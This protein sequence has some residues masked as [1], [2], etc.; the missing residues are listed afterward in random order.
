MSSAVNMAGLTAVWRRQVIS[1]LGNPLGYLFILAFVVASA[2]ILFLPETFFTRNL[3]DLGYLLSWDGFPMMPALLAVLV[4]ALGMG[5][6][7]AERESGT[8]E[9]LLTMPFSLLDAVLGK[10]FAVMTFVTIALGCSLSNVAIL[11]WIGSPDAGLVF[12]NYLGWWLCAAVFSA[13]SL[14]ASVLVVVPAFAFVLGMLFCLTLLAVGVQVD[15]FAGFNRGVMPVSSVIGA[16]AAAGAGLGIVLLALASRRWR[17]GHEQR[18]FLHCLSAVLALV[19]AVNLGR[20]G[21]RFGI[22]T[23]LSNDGIASLASESVGILQGLERPVQVTAFISQRLP[24]G[25]QI[26]AKRVEDTLAAIERFGGN[27]VEVDILRPRNALSDAALHAQRDF[28]LK[29]RK[30]MVDT[31]LGRELSDVYLSVAITSA[32]RTHLIEY[33]DPGLHVEYELLQGIR[34]V[35][36]DAKRVIGV[37]RTDLE[38]APGF[39][40][41]TQQM[42]P[43]WQLYEQWKK[44]Y[45]VRDVDLDSAVAAEI[46]VLVV[47]QP[48]GLTDAQ[49]R[50]L[51][52]YIW[53]G[54]PTLLMEDPLPM[55]SGP[56]LAAGQPRRQQGGPYGQPDQSEPKGNLRPLWRSLGL[57]FNMN[58]VVWSEYN[59]SHAHR[60][61]IPKSFV[62]CHR[63]G[64]SF[65]DSPLTRGFTDLLFAW[66]G[67][68]GVATDKPSTITVTPLVTATPGSNWGW[69]A[70]DEYF[71]QGWGGMQQREITRWIPAMDEV[72]AIAVQVTGKM[73][74][75]FPKP[76][77]NAPKP[78]GEGEAAPVEEREGIPSAQDINVIVVADT[79]FCNDMFFQFYRDE[80]SR[81]SQQKELTFLKDLRNV[82]FAANLVDGLAGEEGLVGVRSRLMPLRKLDFIDAQVQKAVQARNAAE[83]SAKSAAEAQI[84]EKRAALEADVAKIDQRSDL[85]AAAKS[86]LKELTRANRSRELEVD[87][88]RINEQLELE[89]LASRAE[90]ERRIEVIRFQ[91]RTGAI[92]IPFLILAGIALLVF[93]R[94]VVRESTHVPAARARS[95][96]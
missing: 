93:L 66:P 68:I 89:N 43:A 31:S 11:S 5:A 47:P 53:D 76:D 32:G 86:E 49:I 12:A 16:I 71:T 61:V 20:I 82:Q 15:F 70:W 28:G 57:D 33:V 42:R 64:T 60:G 35:G 27:K 34:T 88:D 55:F 59:P 17:P 19:L 22:D 7:A 84:A 36:Y 50:N 9:L 26:T 77:P 24:E 38:I 73:P 80:G 56:D 81:L 83:E 10:Y 18:T 65:A 6:W 41:R 45:D 79:D 63:E 96:A 74:S 2:A 48:S 78:E 8:E 62:W 21:V 40:M 75:A 67:K 3:S 25:V 87:I 85:D 69:H 94:R 23:D 4:P 95:Q 37:A 90:Q 14:L 39:D 1:L 46:E 51:H 29:P 92:V 30:D 54:R 44:Q 72:P 58:A 13:F 52:D 91:I